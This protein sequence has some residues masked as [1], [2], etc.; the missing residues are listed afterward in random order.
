MIVLDSD[1][2]TLFSYR[3]I[4]KLNNRIEQAVQEDDAA[5]ATITIMEIL[6]GRFAAILKAAFE[7][8][9]LAAAYRFRNSR[10]LLN[11]FRQLEINQ[12]AARRFQSM[13]ATTK[14]N[15]R[16]KMKRGDMIIAAIALAHN[17]LLVSRNIKDYRTVTGLRVENWAD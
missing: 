9:L 5:V 16:S 8:E 17:A 6:Q 13:T 3:S 10:D 15:K 1:I 4:E 11:S 7:N 12:D 2:V 14:G